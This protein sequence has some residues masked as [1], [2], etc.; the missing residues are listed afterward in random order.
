M[1]K[2]AWNMIVLVVATAV[3]VMSVWQHE[4]LVIGYIWSDPAVYNAPFQMFSV[5][6]IR[7]TVGQGYDLTLFLTFLALVMSD[8]ALSFV[9]WERDKLGKPNSQRNKNGIG[10]PPS[11]RLPFSTTLNMTKHQSIF[12]NSVQYP[13]GG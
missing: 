10:N 12:K 4:L 1:R 8:L 6:P 13:T 2:H 11:F 3:F 5:P 9:R 7:M